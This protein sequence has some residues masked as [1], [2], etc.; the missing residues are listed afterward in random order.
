MP[1]SLRT[2]V[3]LSSILLGS[4]TLPAQGIAAVVA[5]AEKQGFDT[6]VC[7]VGLDDGEVVYAH[8]AGRPLLPA[9]NQKL[10]TVAAALWA[11]GVDYEFRTGFRLRQGQLEVVAGGDPNWLAGSEHSAAAVFGRVTQALARLGVERIR[12]IRLVDQSFPGPARPQ[13]W[14]K[15]Q[16][17]RSYCAPTSGLVLEASCFSARISPRPSG[18]ARI[19]ILEP[20]VEL[21]IDG[22]IKID[23]VR[24]KRYSYWIS[25]SVEGFRGHGKIGA[26]VPP[27]TVRGVVQ[28][29]RQVF[30]A[31]LER[32]LTRAGLRIDAAAPA[33]DVDLHTE[34]SSLLAALEPILSESSNFHA[35]QLLRVLGREAAGVGDFT[36]GLQV[37]R[38]QL[39]EHLGALPEGLRLADGSGLSR[40]NKV[41]AR[42][43]VRV[44]RELCVAGHGKLLAQKLARG[45]KRGTL[46]RRFGDRPKLG[47]AVW[48]KTGT[49]RGVKTLS[50]LLRRPDGEVLVFSILM[51][52]R[53]AR[54]TRGASALQEQMLAA[55][56]DRGA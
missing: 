20:P 41:P 44:I 4:A 8:R 12:G 24:R 28:H 25:H 27:V 17:D 45:G 16:F 36:H 54:S 56:Y 30:A 9:S 40:G 1:R 31:A 22:A 23:R 13:G 39:Q 53:R 26:H 37:L 18:S 5:K 6:G 42:F 29:P 48:A 32:A 47:A 33:T 21:P 43:L 15:D 50:G 52:D 46:R 10:M 11:L 2:R 35:E 19:E 34:R 7:V 51:N 3:V 38:A 14:P 55:L 49:I